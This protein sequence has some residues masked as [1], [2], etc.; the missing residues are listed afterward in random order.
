MYYLI[1]NY[2]IIVSSFVQSV[3]QYLSLTINSIYIDKITRD[4]QCEFVHNQSTTD[5]ISCI[6]QVLQ[7]TSSM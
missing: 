3:I 4:E 1:C 6:C 7:K 2:C 5:Q